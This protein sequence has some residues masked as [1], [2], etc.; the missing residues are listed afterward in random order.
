MLFVVAFGPYP[1]AAA[2]RCQS[3]SSGFLAFIVI[4]KKLKHNK[5]KSMGDF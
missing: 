1:K 4:V 3:K 5:T 2:F